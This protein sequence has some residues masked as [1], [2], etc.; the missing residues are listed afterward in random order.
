M[1]KLILLLLF[2][3]SAF[4]EIFA[5]L[6]WT[7]PGEREDR[8]PFSCETELKEF[9]VRAATSKPIAEWEP[10]YFGKETTITLP[11]QEGVRYNF[12]VFAVDKGNLVSGPA[13]FDPVFVPETIHVPVAAPGR[14]E[15][16][17]IKLIFTEE[18]PE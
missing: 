7:C 14:I 17:N 4:A 12:A 16:L 10:L 2:S 8:T 5:E 9:V 6:S 11:I 3:T 13:L 15:S 18:T 1:I